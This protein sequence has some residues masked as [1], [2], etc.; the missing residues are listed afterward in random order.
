MM[1]NDAY[2]VSNDDA[3][4]WTRTTWNSVNPNLE[5]II[6]LIQF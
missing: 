5:M 6:G 2:Y 3:A 1:D 4:S